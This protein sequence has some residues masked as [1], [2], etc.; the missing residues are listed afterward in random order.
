MTFRSLYRLE[1]GGLLSQADP[2]HE[3]AALDGSY[4]LPPITRTS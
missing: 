2:W 4:E 3:D 1:R